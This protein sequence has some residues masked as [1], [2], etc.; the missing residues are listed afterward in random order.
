METTRTDHNEFAVETL[1]ILLANTYVMT[2]K[3]QHVH[4]NVVGSGFIGIHGITCGQSTDLFKATDDIAERIRMIGGTPPTTM[5]RLLELASIGSEFTSG[6]ALDMVAELVAGHQVICNE[7]KSSCE[8]LAQSS[9]HGTVSLLTSRLE[10]HEK[11]SWLL[12]SVVA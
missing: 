6:S 1:S 3:T 5:E 12:G 4:W 7:I 8:S 11:V 10:Y 9:D 2:L